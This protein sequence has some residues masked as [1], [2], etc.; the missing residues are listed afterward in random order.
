MDLF[1]YNIV[2]IGICSKRECDLVL[3]ELAAYIDE[4]KGYTG[5]CNQTGRLLARYLMN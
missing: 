5:R 3:V 4:P 2:Q 1:V